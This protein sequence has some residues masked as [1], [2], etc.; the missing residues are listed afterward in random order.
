M[1]KRL[2]IIGMA[3]LVACTLAIGKKR[4]PSQQLWPNGEPMAAWFAEQGKVDVATLGRR[5]DVTKHI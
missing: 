3:L 5:Y 4:V 2:L 1:M